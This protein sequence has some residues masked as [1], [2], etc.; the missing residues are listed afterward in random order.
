MPYIEAKMER[1][2]IPP[3]EQGHIPV[4]TKS[5]HSRFLKSTRFDWGHVQTALGDGWTVTINP[6][7]INRSNCQHLEGFDR[8]GLMLGRS[9]KDY[10]GY[11]CPV[12]HASRYVLIEN[13]ID[14]IDHYPTDHEWD[15]VENI[16]TG[17]CGRRRK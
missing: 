12:C 11:Q 13:E 14:L 9:N 17:M 5:D 4:V 1:D 3:Y 16:P 2:W 15:Y 6:F 7:E 8:T 10:R